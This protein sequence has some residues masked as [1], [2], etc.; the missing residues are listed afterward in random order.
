MIPHLRCAAGDSYVAVMK[1]FVVGMALGSTLIGATLQGQNLT[2]ADLIAARQELEEAEKM[3]RSDI[4]TLQQRQDFLER[5]V[6][7][8]RD[9]V[10]GMRAENTALKDAVARMSAGYVNRE[11]LRSVVEKVQEVDRKRGDDKE[12]ILREFRELSKLPA[13]P[14]PV[15]GPHSPRS[16]GGSEKPVR[17][18]KPASIPDTSPPKA[19]FAGDYYPHKVEANQTLGEIITAYNKQYEMKVKLSD[20]M[21]ANP[22][23]KDPKK[24]FVGQTVKIPVVK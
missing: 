16:T 8:L 11:E 13:L 18:E 12:L 15:D 3:I 1:R 19:E 24:L 4:S 17:I 9:L 23:L 5:E 21:K 7:Q 2:G 6:R 22:K 10:S 14:A 20:V